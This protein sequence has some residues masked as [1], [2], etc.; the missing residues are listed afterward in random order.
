MK[1]V[2]HSKATVLFDEESM[3][4][5]PL[6]TQAPSSPMAQSESA[7]RVDI[8]LVKH[9]TSQPL[10]TLLPSPVDINS[11]FV[12]RPVLKVQPTVSALS[13][14]D[15]VSLSSSPLKTTISRP[16]IIPSKVKLFSESKFVGLQR[17]LTHFNHPKL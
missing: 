10:T 3:D 12:S 6:L 9:G 13:N 11:T 7:M 17:T 16:K 8:D 5:T 14:T 4:I 2:S 15:E 1:A